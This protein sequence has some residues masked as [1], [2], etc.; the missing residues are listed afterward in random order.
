MTHEITRVLLVEDNPGDAR[1]IRE[2]VAEAK[3]NRFELKHVSG[4]SEAMKE[5]A[6]PAPGGVDVVLLDLSLPDSHGFATFGTIHARAPEIPIIILSGHSDVEMAVKAVRGG[7]QDYLVKGEVDSKQLGRA[8][9][10]AMERKQ[11]AVAF[12][13]ERHLLRSLIDCLPDSIYFK[14][15]E[16][17]FVRVNKALASRLGLD[18]PE[19]ALGKTD[20]D[21]FSQEHAKEAF[22]D[23]REVMKTGKPLLNKE[24]KESWED[25]RVAWVST[26]K[27]PL[28]DSDGKVIGTFG[29][30]RDTTDQKEAREAIRDE[31]DRAQRY[32]DIAG[33]MILAINTEG[34]VTLVNK[35]GCSILRCHEKE[36]VGR[37][38]FDNFIPERYRERVRGISAKLLAG[39]LGSAEHVENPVLTRDGEERFIAWHN[40]PMMDDLGRII[41]HLSSGEDI[42]DRK[43]AEE[44]LT[45]K[46]TELE[47]FNLLAVDR[48]EKMIDLKKEINALLVERG[49][50]PKYEIVE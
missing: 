24:E 16:S 39:Q 34:D 14:D 17:R 44:E 29:V 7:A 27:M 6:D 15:K 42:T 11:A 5:V 13:R 49:L 4:L 20:F 32:L 23:E 40:A 48:E 37:N 10:Y 26:T 43:R 21:F 9:R 19:E 30:S 50:E 18:N 38:W 1:L 3:E 22:A 8:I 33:V 36:I 25:G 41:G 47:E 31:R 35:K 46:M 12:A 45:A 2:M 28:L